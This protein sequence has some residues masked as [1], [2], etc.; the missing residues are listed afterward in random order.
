MSTHNQSDFLLAAVPDGVFV[1]QGERFVFCNPS[2]A[3][4]IGYSVDEFVGLTFQQV[5][6]PK[7]LQTWKQR[8]E[9]RIEGRDLSENVELQ[10]MCK[11]GAH[12][13]V[14]LRANLTQFDGR[15]A[16][17][18][19]VRDITERRRSEERLDS[20][21]RSAP[22]PL[23]MVDDHKNIVLANS[24]AL[25][26]F[27]Y[28]F[29][30][31]IGQ[32]I[33]TLLPSRAHAAH[34]TSVSQYLLA[35]ETRVMGAG[36]ELSAIRKNGEEFP[37]EV[38]LGPIQTSEG[39][40]VLA[41]VIDISDQK[42]A[43]A[44]LIDAKLKS[45]VASRAKSDFLANMSHEIRTPMNAIIGLTQLTLDTNL[46]TK[47][48]EYLQKVHTSSRAL[49][50]ILDDILDYS[51]IEAG[52]LKMENVSFDLEDTLR[53]MTDLFSAQIEKKGLELFIETDS[54][55]RHYLQGDP[56]RL[57]QILNNLVGNAIK[58]TEQGEIH[59]Q[60][61]FIGQDNQAIEL[62][63]SVRDTGIGMTEDQSSQLFAAF[64]QADTSISRKY[65]GS[66][67]GLTISR[68]LIQ[69]MGGDI[70]FCSTP[71]LGST[72]TF[73]A[74]FG[75]SDA[76]SVI[77]SS[78]HPMRVLL[79]DDQETSLTI[80]EQYLQNWDFDVSTTVSGLEAI[81]KLTLADHQDQAFELLI[82]DWKMPELD[83][84]C[85]I[86]QTEALFSSG[87]LSRMPHII[88]MTAHDKELLLKE[89]NDTRIDSLLEKP[90]TPS[91]LFESLMRI[92]QPNKRIKFSREEQRVDLF[93]LAEPIRGAKI[94]LVED[95]DINQEV[96]IEFLAK[97]G[98]LTTIANHGAEAVNWVKKQKFDAILMDLQMP[99]MDGFEATRLIRELPNGESLPII[100]LSAAAMLQ[101]KQ[102]CKTASM[103]DHISKPLEPNKLIKTLVRL[104]KPLAIDTPKF[105]TESVASELLDSDF[106][107]ALEGF[108]LQ[109]TLSRMD[110][111]EA[112]LRKLLMRFAQDFADTPEQLL[113]FLKQN[114]LDEAAALLHRLKGVA[115]TIGAT[116]LAKVTALFEIDL[117]SDDPLIP[118]PA[119]N[120][121]FQ[122]TL[123]ALQQSIQPV[124]D[125]LQ[126]VLPK[127]PPE[128]K[129]LDI[130]WLQD[131]LGR[132]EIPSDEDLAHCL[133]SLASVT[134]VQKI[135][136]L[137]QFL[138]QFDF[139]AA[140]LLL[141]EINHQH[142]VVN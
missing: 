110:G 75:L 79:V 106:P 47:Q 25:L 68:K 81:D 95:V 91:R 101:D 51:K 83:G 69:M 97:A 108:D 80:L 107:N 99:V 113:S 17:L 92:Q 23:F 34:S 120:R 130:D 117:R 8:F 30:E 139:N 115:A 1:A 129:N 125:S 93:T 46:T 35:P 74:H 61:E 118:F 11:N 59:V 3:K 60:V 28:E 135:A 56:F 138:N 16:A 72:F 142:S 10:L 105:P 33:N 71:G 126:S 39:N 84:L 22:I 15:N 14:E 37:V 58:F 136:A 42:Q 67:L 70:H 122:V 57:G 98:L 100:A 40:F 73:N 19:V 86:R 116:T 64:T 52:K 55:I 121:C 140:S 66:G 43:Q 96:A 89:A 29:H 38:G 50:N 112:L 77:D 5:V 12:L 24:Q 111:N 88:M 94:L 104:I 82:V 53:A 36:R 20:I 45:E 87:S 63:F 109:T 32:S 21:F 62:R 131:C 127:P 102:A 132:H 76:Q 48:R 7:F 137:E 90:V 65:G 4:L 13:W 85:L 133:F 141:K 27:G 18:A 124:N 41:T 128:G 123:T 6:A 134:S 26:L 114:Q 103:D 119:F 31:L 2:M 54:R 9:S 44:L 49:L 78:I